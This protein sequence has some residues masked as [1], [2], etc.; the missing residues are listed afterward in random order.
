MLHESLLESFFLR[1]SYGSEHTMNGIR[2][3]ME[4]H[5]LFYSS[6]YNSLAEARDRPK[7]LAVIALF[8]D[9][10]TDLDHRANPFTKFL[11]EIITPTMN[12][13]MLENEKFSL[14]EVLGGPLDWNYITYRGSLTTP[15]CS[16]SVIWIVSLKPMKISDREVIIDWDEN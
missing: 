7:G 2:Y 15:P 4:I 1:F 12:Y 3:P 14:K 10:T 5:L 13:T 8:Y 16:Q 9:I 11:I 6:I